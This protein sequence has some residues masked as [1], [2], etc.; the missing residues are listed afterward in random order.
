MAAILSL[1]TLLDSAASTALAEWLLRL[2]LITGVAYGFVALSRRTQPALRHA[3]AAGSLLAVV[4]LPAVSAWLPAVSVPVLPARAVEASVPSVADRAPSVRVYTPVDHAA[5]GAI[6]APIAAISGEAPPAVATPSVRSRIR[7]F[8]RESV[9]STTHWVRLA[10]ALWVLV[11]AA[12]LARLALAFRRAAEISRAGMPVEDDTL[13]TAIDRACRVLGVKRRPAVVI[14]NAVSVPMVAGIVRPTILLPAAAASWSHPRLGVVLLHEI[15]HIRR[16]DPAWALSTNVVSAA[17]WFHPFV[18]AL[19]REVRRDSELACDELVLGSGVRASEYA[20]HLVS[21]A[22]MSARREMSAG[23]ALAFAS[24][25]TLEQRVTSIL[26]TRPRACS[27]RAAAA[28]AVVM[29]GWFVAVA[30]AQ[31]TRATRAA[32]EEGK[33]EYQAGKEQFEEEQAETIEMLRA[34]RP[35]CEAQTAEAPQAGSPAL[36]GSMQDTQTSYQFAYNDTGDDPDEDEDEGEDWYDRA[37]RHYERERYE[38]AGQAYES[39]ARFGYNRATAY[40]NAG[41]SYALANQSGKALDM[42]EAAFEEGFDDL[43]MYASDSDLNSLRDLPRFKKLMDSVMSSDEVG[44]RRRAATRDFERLAG[45]KN[46]DEGDWGDVG[47]ELLRAGDYDRAAT[48]FDNEYRLSKNMDEDA[49]YNKACARS[50]GGKTDEALTLLEQSILGGSVSAEHMREDPDLRALHKNRKFDELVKLAEDLDLDASGSFSAG[51]WSFDGKKVR[52]VGYA[53]EVKEWKKAVTHYQE[54]AGRH[55]TAGRAWHNLGFAQLRAEQAKESTASFQKALD[56]GFKPPVTM[57]NL[58]CATALSG[59]IDAA[60]AWL[61]KSEK[62]GFE[63]WNHARWDEDLDP[64][65]AD[66]RYRE[67]KA[68]WKEEEREHVSRHEVHIQVD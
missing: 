62:A 30:V 55:P 23:S 8:A 27:V 4:L 13:V 39:A 21:I 49:L 65:R 10:L 24:R 53:E 15:A 52:K 36:V 14:S 12:L 20:G 16:H 34:D 67:L 59:E 29:A 41:C 38:Q 33:L 44:Q 54:M 61:D 43:D 46:A 45:R 9:R 66:P 6:D 11:A 47:I 19:A 22:T 32:Y 28:A 2:T 1:T 50:L 7:E 48:A 31:P 42:L 17:L 25:S 3:I 40:Y 63:V 68:R 60:F 35:A 51:N 57:Y 18:R 26:S 5:A 56:L 58:A 37:H 64:L